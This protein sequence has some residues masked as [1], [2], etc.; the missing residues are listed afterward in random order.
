MDHTVI[1]NALDNKPVKISLGGLDFEFNEPPMQKAR[2][3]RAEYLELAAPYEEAMDRVSKAV[4]SKS[5]KKQMQISASDQASS[6]RYVND[7]LDWLMKTLEVNIAQ[8]NDIESGAT[9]S[10]IYIAKAKIFGV[11]NAPLSGGETSTAPP[12]KSTTP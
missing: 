3:I 7:L 9:D 12:Q 6:L 4:S 10:E 11:L 1:E 8:R 5:K 2:I